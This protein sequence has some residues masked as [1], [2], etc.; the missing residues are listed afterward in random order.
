MFV[1]FG[2]ASITIFYSVSLIVKMIGKKTH[3]I[4]EYL[5][6]YV[7]VSSLYL[8]RCFSTMRLVQKIIQRSIV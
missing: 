6:E 1:K 7:F 4:V 8:H 3:T 2:F 5:T